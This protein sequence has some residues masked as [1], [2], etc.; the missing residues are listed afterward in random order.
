LNAE[1]LLARLE[2][3]GIQLRADAGRLLLN[4]PKGSVTGELKDAIAANKDALLSLLAR[5]ESVRAGSIAPLD[6]TLPLP[7]STFQERLWILQRITPSDTSFNFVAYWVLDG[8]AE[9]AVLSAVRSLFERHEVLRSTFRDES[10]VLSAYPQ[11]VDAVPFDAEDLR[12]QDTAAANARVQALL[13]AESTRP[14]ELTTKPPVRVHV[15]RLADARWGVAMSVHHIALDA[16]SLGLLEQELTETARSG[17]VAPPP[18]VQYADFAA[19]QRSSQE[20][21]VVASD[22]EWWSKKLAG[23]PQLSLFSPDRPHLTDTAGAVRLYRFAPELTAAVRRLARENNVTPYMVLVA[24]TAAVLR[25]HTGQGEAVFGSPMGV[26]ELRETES[27]IGPFVNLLLLRL[28]LA[29]DPAFS[30]LLGRVRDALLDAHAH[31]NVSF[32]SLLEKLKPPRTFDHSPLFQIALVHHNAP[33]RSGGITRSGG[34][35]HEITMY[36]R[37]AEQDGLELAFEYRAGLF[38]P[39]AIDRIDSHIEAVL[40]RAALVAGTRLSE[41]CVLTEAERRRVVQEFNATDAPRDSTVFPRVF[42]QRASGRTAVAA[43]CDGRTISYPE[44]NR[45]ANQLARH[46]IAN[47]ATSGSRVAVCV[48]RSL[49]LL[50]ALLAVQ[51]SGAAYV[52][53]DPGFP[54]ERLA[55]MLKDSRA[56]AL[57]TAGDAAEGLE[58]PEGVV[59]LAIDADAA[60]INAL[61]AS[62]PGVEIL[63]SDPAYVLYTSGSTGRPKGVVVQHGA[64]MNFLLS[65]ARVPGLR[66]Q[67]V[68]AAVTTISFDIAG[69]ELYLPLLVGARIE[70][71]PREIAADGRELAERLASSG[72]TLL[73]ATPATWR[74]LIEAG[75]QGAAGFRALCGGE[76]LPR[77]LAADLLTR[78]EELWNLYG[79]TETTIWSTVARIGRDMPDITIGKPIDNTQVYLRDAAGRLVPPGVAGEIWIGGQ[80]VA[81]GYHDR[82]EL[83]SERFVPDPYSAHTGAKLY[84][85]GDLGRWRDDGRLEHLGRLDQ[86]VK[87]R[88]FRIE[89]GEI[90][91]VLGAHPAIR[92]AVVVAR[93]ASPS[94]LRLVAYVVYQ[95][96]ED[97]TVSE[98]RRYL[99]GELPDYMIPSLV[100]ALD[101]VPL[102]P[103][104][105]VDRAALP[106][107]FKAAAMTS[108]ASY[109]P[110]ALGM[111]EMLAR[112]WSDVLKVERVS[113]QDNF[114]ELGGHS[115]LSLRVAAAVEKESGWR[116]DPRVLFFQ[117][118]SQIAAMGTEALGG[119][120]RA[121]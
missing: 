13:D 49:D 6:R 38:T 70:L 65:M 3:Q 109:E 78:V 61:D 82:P 58:L 30:T 116:M 110:P 90:E 87:I 68:L 114:F 29:D 16:W 27:M 86:Q 92:Q 60:A 93:A 19:W 103:N 64:L 101:A 100:V 23:A 24:A 88:G 7:V 48:H 117:P 53:L 17:V 44:L 104:G 71:V 63:P 55:F 50:V 42:G 80:G 83:T 39:E 113:A 57:L 107:P 43:S 22:L 35:M 120:A 47:G 99:R 91:V 5:R 1:L 45:R 12:A 9:G 115:L 34:A 67:D 102:T 77:D 69:L 51:K 11:P 94:D 8:V 76:A 18:A 52:P 25:W 20:P 33:A 66:E 89:L 41:L 81:L 85:T 121:S 98:V 84:R 105:K 118:L 32:E 119:T 75:W 112:I 79:P 40:A 2:S 62:E 108:S 4:A 36:L 74:L 15:F 97:L 28:D 72:A 31:R 73:Q 46:L 10:G 37:E 59:L 14:F 56:A 96:G 111:E 26:R 95:Q 54:P 106:D 21:A